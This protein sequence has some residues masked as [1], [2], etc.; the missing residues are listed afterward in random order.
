MNLGALRAR[1]PRLLA[2]AILLPALAFRLLVPAGFMPV[3]GEGFTLG[4]QMCHGAGPLPS[5]TQ[6][7]PSGNEPAPGQ[8]RHDESPCVFAAAGSAAPPPAPALAAAVQDATDLGTPALDFVS[9][10]KAL[11]RAQAARAPPAR[12]PRA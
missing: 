10:Q 5:A 2:T 9:V 6:P 8:E 12:L 7:V 1:R 3:A 4:V 11:H